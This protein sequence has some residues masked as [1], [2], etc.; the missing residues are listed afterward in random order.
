MGGSGDLGAGAG[1][2]I[3]AYLANRSMTDRVFYDADGELLI[4]PQ[5]GRLRLVTELGVL[6]VAPG[7][8]AVVPRGLRFRVDLLYSAAP[9]YIC[10][11]PGAVPLV[12][13]LGAARAA[14]PPPPRPV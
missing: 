5:Q 2:A 12:P 6:A 14:G 7:E 3:P 9:G 8:I 4:V 10:A 11:N 13:E 1:N